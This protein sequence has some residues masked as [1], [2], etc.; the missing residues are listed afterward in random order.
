MCFINAIDNKVL[1]GRPPSEYRASLTTLGRDDVLERALVP[2][3]ELFSDDFFSFIGE[4]AAM[5]TDVALALMS[6]APSSVEAETRVST[7]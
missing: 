3:S 6:T 5:L 1:G 7:P 2:A 4:R